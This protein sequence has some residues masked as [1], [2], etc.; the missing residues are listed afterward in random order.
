MQLWSFS[1]NYGGMFVL[2]FLENLVKNL[3]AHFCHLMMMFFCEFMTSFA[4]AHRN[5][6]LTEKRQCTC[7]VLTNTILTNGV[8][9]SVIF[10]TWWWCS[11]VN[12]W[13]LLLMHIGI[14]SKQKKDGALL[15]F[16]PYNL[17]SSK[18]FYN[19]YHT[20]WHINRSAELAQKFGIS[21]KTGFIGCW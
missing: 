9:S 4:Y 11:S 12:L 1:A 18:E 15:E 5:I 7:G 10:V 2:E 6:Q 17:S 14:Y 16:W 13:L 19:Q 21:L 20:Y 8:Y 3:P